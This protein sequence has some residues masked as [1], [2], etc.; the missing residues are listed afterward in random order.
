MAQCKHTVVVLKVRGCV[1]ELWRKLLR[2]CLSF[3]LVLLQVR[4]S[5]TI[6]EGLEE[7]TRTL[8]RFLGKNP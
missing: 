1:H 8:H 6:E 7:E 2:L 5:G 4:R 3:V